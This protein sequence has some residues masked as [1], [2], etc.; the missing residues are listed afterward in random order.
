LFLDRDQ[1]GREGARKAANR[2]RGHNFEVSVF[3]WDLSISWNG[4]SPGPL[5]NSIEDPAD[6]SV[7]Q[8]CSLRTRGII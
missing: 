2:L 3:D 8:L 4:H 6:M 5:P 1:A 7:E